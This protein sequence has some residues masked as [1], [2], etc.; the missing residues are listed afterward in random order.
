M[1][2]LRMRPV[3]ELITNDASTQLHAAPSRGRGGGRSPGRSGWGGRMPTVAIPKARHRDP[4]LAK[5]ATRRH[6]V[7]QS[8]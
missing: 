3:R 2:P 7:Q 5:L 6:N 1:I 8:V 4:V